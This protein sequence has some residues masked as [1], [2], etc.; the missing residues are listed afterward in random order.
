MRGMR[1][2]DLAPA[3]AVSL[4]LVACAAPQREPA[5]ADPVVED[6]GAADDVWD[7]DASLKENCWPDLGNAS[8]GFPNYDPLGITP[9]HHCSG[10]NH[11]DIDAVEKVVFLGDSITAGTPPTPANQIY[12]AVLTESLKARFGED[13]EVADC[14]E[15]GARTDDYLRDQIPRCFPGIE[16]KRT[17]VITTMGGNDTFAAASDVLEGGGTGDALDTLNR[18]IAYQ[19][20]TMRWFRDNEDTVF[21][22]GVFI[23]AGNVYEFTD[24]TGDMSSCPLAET[25][26]FGGVVPELRDAYIYLNEAFVEIAVETRT[27]SIWMLESFCGHGFYAG[28]P[29]NECYRGADAE[30]WFDATCIHPNPAGH[31]AVAQ[32]FLDVVAE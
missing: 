6:S 31:A 28:D 21:P 25:F 13:L 24:A 20:D 14:S 17:L 2:P 5:T 22:A 8:G 3:L 19:R 30:V 26:G 7:P 12:R 23:I 1:S 9:G 29:T 15:F 10:T 27:D 16:P 11:Q 32:M 4:A 18:A